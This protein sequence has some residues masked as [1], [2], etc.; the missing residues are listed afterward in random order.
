MLQFFTLLAA[1]PVVFAIVVVDVAIL[2][3]VFIGLVRKLSTYKSRA[4]IAIEEVD[5]ITSEA[6]SDYLRGVRA[7][8]NTGSEHAREAWAEYRKTLFQSSSGEVYSTDDAE[9][10]FNTR[11]LAPELFKDSR[12]AAVP[13]ML[14]AIGVLATFVGLSVGLSGIDISDNAEASAL[15]AGINGLISS[16]G[17]SFVTSIAGVGASL[18]ATARIKAIEA[19]MHECVARLEADVDSRFTRYSAERGLYRMDQH[20]R[21]SAEALAQLHEKIGVQLQ[22]AVQGLSADMQTAF[23]HAINDALAPAVE[24]LTTDTTKQSAEVF[25]ALVG[26]F[27]GAFEQMGDVQATAMRSASDGLVQSVSSLSSEVGNSITEMKSVSEAERT[28]NKEALEAMQASA[29]AQVEKIHA[30]ADSQALA[31]REAARE[32]SESDRRTTATLMEE[33]RSTSQEQMKR[34]RDEAAEQTHVLQSQLTDL[35]AL[36]TQQHESSQRTIDQLIELSEAARVAMAESANHLSSTSGSLEK[37]AGEFSTA[38]REVASR[39]ADAAAH[40]T[41]VNASQE[42]SLEALDRHSAGIDRITSLS[43]STAERLS[44]AANEAKSSFELMQVHQNEF[45]TNLESAL[46][47]AQSQLITEIEQVSAAMSQWLTQY[48]DDVKTQTNDRMDEWNRQTV[49]F[50]S[51]LLQT[52]QALSVVVEEIEGKV[53]NGSAPEPVR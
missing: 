32:Q 7:G 36:T 51:T 47:R 26:K 13:S 1:N 11:T 2:A 44:Q 6:E 16:A 40:F 9:R 8:E 14:T 17:A 33:L 28:A 30:A 20:T 35:T 48:S 21:E 25:E 45:V 52:S 22:T 10:F 41:S 4:L 37:T 29:V 31:L 43:G 23:V 18:F 50:A 24:Q 39:F 38:S 34:F 15:M 12:I 19:A 27:S 46:T 5:H 49:D 42:R 3:F 53:S